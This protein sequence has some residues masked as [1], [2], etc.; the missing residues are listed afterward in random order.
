MSGPL[1]ILMVLDSFFPDSQGGAERMVDGWCREFAARGHDVRVLAG[2]IGMPAGQE[3]EMGGY[4][5]LRWTSKRRSFSDGYFSAIVACAGSAARIGKEWRPDVV[6]CHQGLSAYAALHSGISAPALC[7]FHSPWRDEFIED[8]R[9]KEETLSP[10]LRPLYRLAS[11]LKAARIHQMEGDALLRSQGAAVLS[12]FSR[13]RLADAHGI[14]PESIGL[15]RGGIDLDRFSPAPGDERAQIRRRLGF[16]GLTLLSVRRLVRRTGVDLLLQAMVQIC[17]GVPDVHLIL[18]GK[19]PERKS[20]E[21]MA[22]EL[23]IGSSVRFAGFIPDEVL[24]DYYRA[25]D[26]FVLPT[27]SLEG[28]GMATVEALASGTPVVGTPVGATPEILGPLEKG[29][30]AAKA[31]A[32]GISRAALPLLVFPSALDDLR[33]RCRSYAEANYRWSDAGDALEEVYVR[34]IAERKGEA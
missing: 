18:V 31:T 19:G 12:V 27:R 26:L 8:A 25:A 30:L 4:R 23:G 15:L 11:I 17:S 29:L 13:G 3:E 5:V 10:A 1:R 20:L 22:D 34:L 33:S 28:F 9:A 32:H 16:A 24:P 21:R 6:H 7:T 2:R 14:P